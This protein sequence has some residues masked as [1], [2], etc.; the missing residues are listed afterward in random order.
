MELKILE[1]HENVELFL[2]AA[3]LKNGLIQRQWKLTPT[4]IL[5]FAVMLLVVW[6]MQGFSITFEKVEVE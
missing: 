1:N 2:S 6:A 3:G 5:V 4:E